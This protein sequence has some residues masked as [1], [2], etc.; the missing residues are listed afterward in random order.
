MCQQFD[1]AKKTHNR[2]LSSS[3]G[4]YIK[5]VCLYSTGKYLSLH[6]EMIA[7]NVE[8]TDGMTVH[9]NQVNTSGYA[10]EF[11]PMSTD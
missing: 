2:G 8:T 10:S 7:L 6:W 5:F 4:R 3:T 1:G 11:T 9:Q